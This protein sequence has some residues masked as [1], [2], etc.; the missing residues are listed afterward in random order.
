M[1]LLRRITSTVKN[2]C[3]LVWPYDLSLLKT[4]GVLFLIGTVLWQ[5]NR[6]YFHVGEARLA[7]ASS[8]YLTLFSEQNAMVEFEHELGDYYAFPKVSNSF[9]GVDISQIQRFT[10]GEFEALV[11]STVPQELRGKLANY[12]TFSMETAQKYQ[13]DPFWVLAVMW[14]ESHFNHMSESS[15]RAI[16]FMQIVPQTGYFITDKVLKKGITYNDVKKYIKEPYVNIELGTIY[17]K[18]LLERFKNNYRLATVAYNLGPNRVLTRLND[19][20]KVGHQN[21]YLNKVALSYKKLTKYYRLALKEQASPFENSYVF[22]ERSLRKGEFFATLL[23]MDLKQAFVNKN[24]KR[25]L[26]HIPSWQLI[27][28]VD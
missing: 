17:L 26:A 24:Q 25:A 9:G 2:N 5:V 23:P 12:L 27:S 21:A 28:L 6:T 11:L 16:G 4:L 13:V 8:L 7:Q 14:T 15:Q 18:R 10:K 22:S 19:G 20:E 1:E 3:R